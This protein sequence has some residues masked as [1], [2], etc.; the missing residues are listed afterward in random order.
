MPAF[1]VHVEN[2]RRGE[3]MPHVYTRER[4]GG[5]NA[6]PPLHI[7]ALP[8][9]TQSVAWAFIDRDAGNYVHWMV[10]D[11]PPGDIRLPQGASKQAMPPGSQELYNDAQYEGYAGPKPPPRTG[12]HRYA[13]EVYALDVPHIDVPT[14][15]SYEQFKQLLEPHTLGVAENYWLFEDNA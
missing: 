14:H 9:G 12:A 4:I 13:I 10:T 2:L 7:E 15:A 3:K 1:G 5:H 11:V 8:P 6:S